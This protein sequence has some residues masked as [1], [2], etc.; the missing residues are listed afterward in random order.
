M[1]EML[2][3]KLRHEAKRRG[4]PEEKTENFVLDLMARR[5]GWTPEEKAKY[6]ENM[7][8]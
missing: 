1:T 2:E 8:K 5:M 3:R 6:K 4:I 7:K